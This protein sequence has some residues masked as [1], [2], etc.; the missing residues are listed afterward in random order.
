LDLDLEVIPLGFVYTPKELFVLDIKFLE[1]IFVVFDILGEF[2]ESL[3]LKI[4]KLLSNVGDFFGLYNLILP[5]DKFEFLVFLKLFS[6]L[7][8]LSLLFFN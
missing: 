8:L 2:I 1:S 6:K 3:N 5:F 7:F 4:F